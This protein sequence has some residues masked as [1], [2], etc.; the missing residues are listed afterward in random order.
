MPSETIWHTSTSRIQMWKRCHIL[1]K[2]FQNKWAPKND[3]EGEKM[4]LHILKITMQYCCVLKQKEKK[5][6]K[7]CTFCPSVRCLPWQWL[8]LFLRS[9]L[10]VYTIF[11][12]LIFVV[13]KGMVALSFNIKTPVLSLLTLIEC[14]S[15][16]EGPF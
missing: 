10:I 7:S 4:D 8:D 14:T 16:P 1:Q 5:K 15:K 13:L 12:Q 6:I 9:Q 3:Q 11:I 2:G